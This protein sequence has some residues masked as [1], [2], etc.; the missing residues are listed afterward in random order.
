MEKEKVEENHKNAVDYKDATTAS[1]KI[2]TYSYKGWLNSDGFFKRVFAIMGY[3]MVATFIF[4]FVFFG[5]ILIFALIIA[6]LK[7][8]FG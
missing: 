6:F 2:D 1:K 8:F 4:Q 5:I 3:Q 7:L